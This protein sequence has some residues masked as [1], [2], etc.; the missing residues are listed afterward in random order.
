[1]TSPQDPKQYIHRPAVDSDGSRVGNITQV[2]VDD[3][4][5]QPLWVLVE[6]GSLRKRPSFAPVH[7]SRVDDEIV[8]LA[9]SKEAV[10]DAP[11]LGR[12]AQLGQNEQDALR[13]HYSGYFASA[14]NTS[15][16]EQSGQARQWESGQAPLRGDG[17]S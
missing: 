4:T 11:N 14:D 12:E 1:M 10:K 6:T 9:V 15:A 13:Q 17:D 8:V 2:Y 16:Y 3:Q 5:E 7:G